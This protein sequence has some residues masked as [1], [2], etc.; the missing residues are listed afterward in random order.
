[1]Q[2]HTHGP[3][4]LKDASFTRI[5]AIPILVLLALCSR[6]AHCAPAQDS[7]ASVQALAPA[8]PAALTVK[9]CQDGSDGQ[10]AIKPSSAVTLTEAKSDA[11]QTLEKFSVSSG[12]GS[13]LVTTH[14]ATSYMPTFNSKPE[15]ST[16]WYNDLGFD[17]SASVNAQNQ[18]QSSYLL[19]EV[20]TR[21]GGVINLY[22]SAAGRNPC[23]SIYT[24]KDRLQSLNHLYIYDFLYDRNPWRADQGMAFISHGLG[25]RA[26]KEQ[27][28][29]SGY[30]G[31]GSAYVGVGFDGPLFNVLNSSPDAKKDSL[32]KSAK[33]SNTATN[34][35]GFISLELYVAEN[36]T[37]ASA[38]STM[39][40]TRTT[41]NTYATWGASFKAGLGG[42][43]SINADYSKAFSTSSEPF[44]KD[45]ILVSVGYN[46]PTETSTCS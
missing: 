10:P 36:V 24:W 21:Y 4:S 32:G 44:L 19:Q 31:V 35:P 41:R 42:C 28:S 33:P 12:S 15:D 46:R 16:H 18:T 38:L 37:S 3:K 22:F 8:A 13:T 17:L 27:L 1:M 26:I 25:Y 6:F 5:T 11:S 20:L 7:E 23:N 2:L 14:I 40:D 34:Q 30:A 29:G 39:F 43:F 45:V 9:E